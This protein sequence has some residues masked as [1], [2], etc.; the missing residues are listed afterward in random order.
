MVQVLEREKCPRCEKDVYD[1]EGF[2]AGEILDCFI[3]SKAWNNFAFI[4]KLLHM[5]RASVFFVYIK[6]KKK[7]KNY[8]RQ[9]L[10]QAMFQMFLVR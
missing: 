2:P 4:S 3:K 8:R 5:T 1:A 9:T 6:S 7:I 10:S